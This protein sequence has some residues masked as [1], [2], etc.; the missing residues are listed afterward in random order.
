MFS[1]FHQVAD[2]SALKQ[3]KTPQGSSVLFPPLLLQLGIHSCLP[4]HILGDGYRRAV[5]LN[6]SGNRKYALYRA[7]HHPLRQA[8]ATVQTT[9]RAGSRVSCT[10]RC[11]KQ[12]EQE[13]PLLEGKRDGKSTAGMSTKPSEQML[14]DKLLLHSF[15]TTLFPALFPLCSFS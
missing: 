1:Y 15:L 5:F 9:L 10:R 12:D 13:N 6:V 14:A 4:T 2:P 11:L 8:P 3:G 7:Q